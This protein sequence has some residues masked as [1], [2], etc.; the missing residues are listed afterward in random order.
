VFSS[1]FCVAGNDLC[2]K[3]MYLYLVFEFTDSV[4]FVWRVSQD[5]WA[6]WPPGPAHYPHICA[7]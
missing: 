7:F 3:I 2:V 5:A 6:S 1:D 4:L